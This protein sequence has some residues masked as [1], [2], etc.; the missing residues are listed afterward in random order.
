MLVAL[1]LTIAG[2]F[3][4]GK[5]EACGVKASFKDSVSGTVVYFK[6]TSSISVKHFSY[7]WHFGDGYTSDTSSPTHNYYN[8]GKSYTACLVIYDSV[9][10]C[11]DTA[12]TT[13]T[14]GKAPCSA[15][16]YFTF[17]N[18]TGG[19]VT[20]TNGSSTNSGTYKSTW[21]FNDKTSSTDKNPTHTFSLNGYYHICLTVTDSANTACTASYCAYDS[22]IVSTCTAHFVYATTKLAI[23]LADSGSSAFTHKH[24]TVWNY[25]DGSSYGSGDYAY[26]TYSKA[27][28]YSVCVSVYDSSTGCSSHYCN[29]ITISACNIKSSFTYGSAG[30]TFYFKSNS[31]T[32]AHTR[33]KWYFGDGSIDSTT[34]AGVSHKYIATDTTETVYLLIYDSTSGCTAYSYQTVTLCPTKSNYTYKAS[35]LTVS[36]AV[37]TSNKASVKYSWNFGDKSALS[38]SH[39]PSHTFA[40]AGTYNVCLTATDSITGCASTTCT[41]LTVTT[42]CTLTA[43]FTDSISGHTVYFYGKTNASSHSRIIWYFGDGA[44]DSSGLDPHHTYGSSVSTEN[45]YLRVYDSTTKCLYYASS[46]ITLCTALSDYTDKISGLTVTFAVNASNKSTVK[47]SWNFGDKSSLSD[48]HAP[49]HTF[50][51]NGTYDVC[52]TATDSATGCSTTTCSNITVTNCSLTASFTDSISGHTVY[53]YGKT[54]ASSHSKIIWFFGDNTTDS[55]SGVNAHHTYTSSAST[56]NVYMRVYDSTTKC[57]YYATGTITFC[58]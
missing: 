39:A 8:Y 58:C 32:S 22:V 28:T 38:D 24:S 50:A 1:M 43:S 12:C 30:N 20:F 16:A 41:N 31:T 27:G 14:T 56:E 37:N 23:A 49:S 57:L 5:T 17:K 42:G 4:S 52:L 25:G 45:V 6:S 21:D 7:S 44:S 40:S 51:S 10:K 13:V 48:S 26:H 55:T 18:G 19:K 47:Y 29:S 54:N 15:K 53:F 46:T 9:N 11:A 3:W 2:L 36:F 34:G 33:Y 35:G